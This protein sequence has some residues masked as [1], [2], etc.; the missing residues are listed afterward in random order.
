ML[1][2]AFLSAKDTASGFENGLRIELRKIIKSKRKSQFFTVGELAAIK[3]ASQ[4]TTAANNAKLLGRLG[5][6]EGQ[7]INIVN[8]LLGG[9]AGA[10]A[11][12]TTGGI[13]VP[14]IGQVS[15]SLAQRLTAKSAR[16]ADQVVRAGGNA[17]EITKAYLRNTSKNKRS[18][19]E[20]SELLVRN[21]I[22]L[23]TVKSAI[24]KEAADI[25][26]QARTFRAGA[27]IGGELRPE[28][29]R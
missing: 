20:L 6:S 22:D 7:A 25:A 27:L 5:F 14:I 18:A 2:E 24:A 11:F 10:A 3:R 1:Q 28:D 29:E 16:F 13:A 21:E 26:R 17:D 9:A 8:P 15:K 12:G 23:D 4:G 19:A